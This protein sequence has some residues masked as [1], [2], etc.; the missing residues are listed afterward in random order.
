M[1]AENLR[2]RQIIAERGAQWSDLSRRIHAKRWDGGDPTPWSD[3]AYGVRSIAD[4]PILADPN[5]AQALR[6]IIQFIT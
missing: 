2:K 1:M 5:G 3:G 6:T 4:C